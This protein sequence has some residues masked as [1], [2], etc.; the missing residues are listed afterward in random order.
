MVPDFPST[1]VSLKAHEVLQLYICTTSI[2]V[3][4]TIIVE[5]GELDSNRKIQHSV[6]FII[7]VLN[8]SKARYFHIM[9]LAYTLLITSHK[10]SHYFQAY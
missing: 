8:D 6:Y 2:V 9:K 1:L 4:T 10:L 3:S 7:D 5:R